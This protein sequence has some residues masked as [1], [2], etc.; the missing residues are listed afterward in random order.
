MALKKNDRAF[1]FAKSI[2]FAGPLG[3]ISAITGPVRNEFP[4]LLH[5]IVKNRNI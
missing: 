4:R 5:V 2:K 3:K 1:N